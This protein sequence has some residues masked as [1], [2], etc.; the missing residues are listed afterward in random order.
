MPCGRD[1]DG[2]ALSRK[3]SPEH[4]TSIKLDEGEL[5]QFLELQM[6]EANGSQKEELMRKK[7]FKLFL[8][9]RLHK[10]C[11]ICK[12]KDGKGMLTLT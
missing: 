12:V 10:A 5:T 11:K 9:N 2:N 6:L 8:K 3:K 1:G 7:K 4:R